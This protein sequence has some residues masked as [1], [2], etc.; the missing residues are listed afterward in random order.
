MS[1]NSKLRNLSRLL[2]FYPKI[3]AGKPVVTYRIIDGSEIL[4]KTPDAKDEHGNTLDPKKR[5]RQA[6]VLCEDHFEKLKS[7]FKDSGEAGVKQYCDLVKGY[8]ERNK[9]AN[10]Q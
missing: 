9:K 2:P 10:E 7:A 4:I 8:Y 5:Y 3:R 6:I 1:T